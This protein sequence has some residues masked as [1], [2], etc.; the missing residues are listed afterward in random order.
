MKWIWSSAL[1]ILMVA[2]SYAQN[3]VIVWQKQG[4]NLCDR[5]IVSPNGTRVGTSSNDDVTIKL[6]DITNGKHL[7]TDGFY[8]YYANLFYPAID[9]LGFTPHGNQ[10]EGGIRSIYPNCRVSTLAQPWEY[11][12]VPNP[13][14]FPYKNLQRTIL[15]DEER[16]LFRYDTSGFRT[17]GS[18][19]I[20]TDQLGKQ[21]KRWFFPEEGLLKIIACPDTSHVGAFNRETGEVVF[22]DVSSGV[23]VKRIKGPTFIYDGQFSLD[24]KYLIAETD[25]NTVRVW[26]WRAGTIVNN[27][28]LS[29][30]QRLYSNDWMYVAQN[31]QILRTLDGAHI[32]TLDVSVPYISLTLAHDGTTLRL[33]YQ[34]VSFTGQVYIMD[35]EG[36]KKERAL[37]ETIGAAS[38]LAFAEGSRYLVSAHGKTLRTW[39]VGARS[40]VN[41]REVDKPVSFMTQT[42]DGGKDILVV[43][44]DSQTIER[45]EASTLDLKQRYRPDFSPTG[46]C[47]YLKESSDGK[48]FA[49]FELDT[50]LYIFSSSGG[51]LDRKPLPMIDVYSTTYDVSTD[52]SQ[53]V[54]GPSGFSDA[55]AIVYDLESFTPG[56][57]I[58]YQNMH[59][60]LSQA[61]YAPNDSNIFFGWSFSDY[62]E[63]WAY[64]DYNIFSFPYDSLLLY[65]YR[66]AIDGC[67]LTDCRW[68]KSSNR[69]YA[70]SS[71]VNG[72][73]WNKLGAFGQMRADTSINFGMPSA[74]YCISVS[75]DEMEYVATAGLDGTITLWCTKERSLDVTEEE[76]P[77]PVAPKLYPNPADGFV[78]VTF[79]ATLLDH[80]GLQIYDLLGNVLN[81]PIEIIS[82]SEISINTRSLAEGIYVIRSAEHPEIFAKFVKI[83]F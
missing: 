14:S 72:G 58:P 49:T 27:L 35:I 10:L 26:D 81:A 38:G 82:E 62:V 43:Y 17:K 45:Y 67:A 31:Y 37:F 51:F 32:D 3:P 54:I 24:G 23:E 56:K 7:G 13:P 28:Q 57:T 15:W 12:V 78:T 63:V 65:G 83:K 1:C 6:W 16:I 33:V 47:I 11:S 46:K 19:F 22:F 69:I 44:Q 74:Q 4:H 52:G 75:Q 66:S 41:I 36:A 76:R 20:L 64:S 30:G 5:F 50:N 80:A 71:N 77:N 70:V 68:N 79:S 73:V 61:R 42:Y 29:P 34:K 25:T 40:I 59:G 2:N 48:L 18:I 55:G 8:T 39:D 21:L 60:Y 53:I 9:T